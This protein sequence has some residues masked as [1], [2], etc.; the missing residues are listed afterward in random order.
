MVTPPTESVLL[1][2]GGIFRDDL[3]ILAIKRMEPIVDTPVQ[4]KMAF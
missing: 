1:F 3:A 2:A 4:E